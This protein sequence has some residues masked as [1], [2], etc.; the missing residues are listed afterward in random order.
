MLLVRELAKSVLA[1]IH[2][3]LRLSPIDH[4][5]LLGDKQVFSASF[6]QQQGTIVE[7]EGAGVVGISGVQVS[8]VPHS[9]QKRCVCTGVGLLLKFCQVELTAQELVDHAIVPECAVQRRKN[10]TRLLAQR[11]L[12]RH[13]SLDLRLRFHLF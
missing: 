12:E 6:I 11:L 4:P 8:S 10:S 7:F 3:D 2:V 5:Q 13:Q 1:R 9:R